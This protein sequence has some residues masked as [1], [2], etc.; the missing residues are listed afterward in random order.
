M[1][2]SKARI[3]HDYCEILAELLGIAAGTFLGLLLTVSEEGL[4]HDVSLPQE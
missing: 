2:F 1:L 4:Y 3:L